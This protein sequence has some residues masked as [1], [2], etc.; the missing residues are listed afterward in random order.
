MV[1]ARCDARYS[2]V[3]PFQLFGGHV[4]S[5]KLVA[6]ILAVCLALGGTEA[7]AQGTR[8]ITGKVTQTGGAPLA[9]ASVTVLGQPIGARTN[10]RGE[11]RLRVP[12]GEV[13]LL[14]RAISF[15]RASVKVAPNASTQDFALEKDVLQLEGVTVTEI[16]RASCRERV[17]PYV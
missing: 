8:E 17:S 13:T 14:V 5:R 4:G 3:H 10:D 2:A 6:A 11:Y 12:Q 9:E 1:T 16:G 7:R 15:K